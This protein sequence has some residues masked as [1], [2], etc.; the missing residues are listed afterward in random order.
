M[1]FITTGTKIMLLALLFAMLL[2]SLFCP[3]IARYMGPYIPFKP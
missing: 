3:E 1:Q 2:I